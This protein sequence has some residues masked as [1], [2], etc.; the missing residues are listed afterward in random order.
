MWNKNTLC[1]ASITRITHEHIKYEPQ[2]LEYAQ[3]Y[4]TIGDK[5]VYSRRPIN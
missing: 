1:R 2:A 4:Q 3:K 5:F